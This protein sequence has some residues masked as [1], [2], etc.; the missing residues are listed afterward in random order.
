MT[1]TSGPI[2]TIVSK[3]NVPY[4]QIGSGKRLQIISGFAALPY[5]QRNQ[6]A[7]FIAS[8]N[9]LLIWGDDRKGLIER[10]DDIQLGIKHMFEEQSFTY[11]GDIIGP[12]GSSKG[13]VVTASAFEARYGSEATGEEKPRRLQLFQCIYTAIAILLLIAAIGSGFRQIAVQQVQDPNWLR[14]IFIIAL[15]AQIWLSLVCH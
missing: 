13:S 15:P 7:A 2:K 14:L 8:H 3:T 6:S 9:L 5:C 4:V 10:A 11:T 1:I 12:K